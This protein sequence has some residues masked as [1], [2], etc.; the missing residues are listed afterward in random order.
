M[1]KITPREKTASITVKTGTASQKKAR[2]TDWWNAA[3]K[4]EL[5][6]QMLS[7]VAYLKQLDG[8]RYRKASLYAHMYGNMPLYGGAGTNLAKISLQKQLPSNRPTM[9]VITSITDTIVSR[10][11]MTKPRPLFVSDNADWQQRKLSKQMNNFIAGEFYQTQFY[12]MRQ[13]VRRDSCV[14]G[15]G[16]YKVLET[17]EK[18]VGLERRL[19][20]QILVDSN[21]AFLGMPRQMYELTLM[22]RKMMEHAFPKAKMPIERAENAY[23][24]LN[25]DAQ[26]TA[27]DLIM[28]VEGWH[29]PSGPG[30]KDGV[31]AM[32]CVEGLLDDESWEE[33]D[34]PFVF[35]HYVDP[36]VG[37]WGQGVAERQLGNQAAINQ[38]L[39]TAHNAIN[40]VGVPRVFVETGS[41]VVKSHLNNNVGAIVEYSGTK[42]SYE[43]APCIPAEIYAEIQNI[44]NRA[45][46]EEGVSQLAA[47][48][49]K[50]KGLNSGEAIRSYDDIQQD[51]L[52]TLAKNDEGM[53]NETADKVIRLARK[54]AKRDGK[55]QTV[56]PDKKNGAQQIDLPEAKELDNPFVVQ[57][58]DTSSL[59]RDPSGRFA[60]ITEWVQAGMY[61][62][63]EGR[64][65]MG[66]P[67]TQQ[68]DTL[69]NAAEERILWQLDKIVEEG[70]FSPPDP[71]TDLSSAIIIVTQYINLYATLKL[72]EERMEMLRNYH[73]QVLDLQGLAMGPSPAAIGA[74]GAP[75]A[76]PEP[77]PTNGLIPNVPGAQQ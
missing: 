35:T 76:L 49:E 55:Y 63:Q 16:V 34:F 18:K 31:H 61:S 40:L 71:F 28:I 3:S 41:K 2:P 27:S 43:V 59:P 74:P 77:A 4:R 46:Q 52:S 44:I 26:E 20:T 69:L 10:M 75:Q 33:K 8:Y 12:K 25:A 51:R 19:S 29:L 62:P 11:E 67:D 50:P 54:I 68:A 65:L 13:T 14:W 23:P 37:F 1:P 53:A 56:Y 7:T 60:K 5:V 39:M 58:Y 73:A 48:S 32:A 45:Y 66:L 21:E 22:D 9:S 17:Q 15:T 42:P 57:C 6:Q 36:Q 30:A 72:E 24:E 38:L 47:Q 70:Q 64:R